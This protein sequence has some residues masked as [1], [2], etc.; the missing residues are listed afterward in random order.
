M[1]LNIILNNLKFKNIILSSKEELMRIREIRN[2]ENIRL[3]MNTNQKIL[4]NEHLDWFKKIKLSKINYFY[5]IKYKDQIVGGLGLNNYDKNLLF[6]EWSYYVSDKSKFVGLGASIEFKAIE[7][8]FNFYKLKSLFCY[9][10]RHNSAVIKLHNKFGFEK[11]SFN[12]YFRNNNLKN[13][14]SNAI[15]LTLNKSK[16]NLI[17]K[18]INK[19][20][21]L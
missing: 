2:E 14:V 10:L 17:N 3:N 20:Y 5:S 6:G 7:Y 18:D 9:V 8:F 21:F 15:Y 13:E 1:K 12:E 11:I 16:W 4:I 19:K